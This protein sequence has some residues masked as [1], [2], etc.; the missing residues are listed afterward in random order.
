MNTDH[1]TLVSLLHNTGYERIKWEKPKPKTWNF[2]TLDK[3][4]FIK[5][6]AGAVGSIDESILDVDKLNTAIVQAMEDTL[7]ATAEL[8]KIGSKPSKTPVLKDLQSQ[9]RTLER[10]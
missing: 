6:L 4:K 1:N 5:T 10:Q 2:G 7:Q 3:Q 8:H 9:V